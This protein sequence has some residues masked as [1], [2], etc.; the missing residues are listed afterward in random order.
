MQSVQKGKPYDVSC[1]LFAV[2][3]YR[4]FLL[5]KVYL[6]DIDKRFIDQEPTS[7]FLVFIFA[8]SRRVDSE[9]KKRFGLRPT[10]CSKETS[11]RACLL[12]LL[13]GKVVHAHVERKP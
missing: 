9:R 2:N 7:N 8:Y 3:I 10:H 12:C 13:P 5:L 11:S 6:T 4:I 1:N